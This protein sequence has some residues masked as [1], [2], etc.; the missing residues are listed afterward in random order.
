[1]LLLLLDADFA[2]SMGRVVFFTPGNNLVDLA[3][4][5]FGGKV[6]SKHTAGCV[7]PI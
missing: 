5:G 6:N 3:Y 7:Q 1:M 2:L 4:P